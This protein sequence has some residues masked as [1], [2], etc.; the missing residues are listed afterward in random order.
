M[1]LQAPEVD[2]IHERVAAIGRLRH[3]EPPAALNER[4]YRR[5]PASVLPQR[6]KSLSRHSCD[7]IDAVV[8]GFTHDHARPSTRRVQHA[9]S[10]TWTTRVARGQ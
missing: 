3:A 2:A 10:E 4:E 8:L 5:T 7:D 6:R 9:Q 1:N